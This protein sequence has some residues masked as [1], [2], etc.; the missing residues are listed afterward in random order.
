MEDPEGSPLTP[1][2]VRHNLASSCL[3]AYFLLD[4]RYIPAAFTT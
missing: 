3:L 2:R 1:L 4:S